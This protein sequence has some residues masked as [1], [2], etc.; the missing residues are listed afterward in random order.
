MLKPLTVLCSSLHGAFLWVAVPPAPRASRWHVSKQP[1]W[2]PCSAASVGSGTRQFTSPQNP[3]LL[4]SDSGGYQVAATCQGGTEGAELPLLWCHSL[5][6][7]EQKKFIFRSRSLL[8]P[9]PHSLD[10][11]VHVIRAWSS[12]QEDKGASLSLC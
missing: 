1:N 7:R 3:E 4:L 10:L 6:V 2:T 5:G 11:Q 8:L 12:C 9:P